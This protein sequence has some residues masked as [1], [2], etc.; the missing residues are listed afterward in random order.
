MGDPDGGEDHDSLKMMMSPPR[1]GG[2]MGGAPPRPSSSRGW[3]GFVKSLYYDEFRWSLVKSVGL[4]AFGVYLAR[5]FKGV[6]LMAA[7]PPAAA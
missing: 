1:R 2:G 4:F 6:D 5:E 7:Q 3:K